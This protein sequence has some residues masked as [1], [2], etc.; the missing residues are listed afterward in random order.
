MEKEPKDMN[1]QE[2]IDALTELGKTMD[3]TK[4][5]ISH[6]VAWIDIYSNEEPKTHK[7][8]IVNESAL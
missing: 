4:I 1:V 8:I 3:L 6:D 5:H 7:Q 2:L